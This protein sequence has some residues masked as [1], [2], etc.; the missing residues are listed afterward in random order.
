VVAV[1][2]LYLLRHAKSD[3]SDARLADHDRPLA[4]RGRNAARRIG[5][6]IAG[7][8]PRPSVVLCS[9]AKRALETWDEIGAG[10]GKPVELRAETEVHVEAEVHVENSLYGASAIDLLARI[11]RLPERAEAALLV[12]H[13]PGMQDLAIDLAGDGDPIGMSQLSE[14][15]PT[16][17]LATLSLDTTWHEVGPGSGYLKSLVIPKQLPE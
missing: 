14:K 9:S 7:V 13:N 12:G 1:R 2:T 4:P 10:L 15:F 8:Q 17:A 11:R 3:W 6:F 16:C 5:R